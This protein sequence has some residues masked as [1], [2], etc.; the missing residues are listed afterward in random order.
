MDSKHHTLKQKKYKR[1]RRN[2]Y[3]LSPEYA[4]ECYRILQPL[5]PLGVVLGLLELCKLAMKKIE[6]LET[7]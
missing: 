6:E 4:V 7:K 5:E 3:G 2:D 1:P